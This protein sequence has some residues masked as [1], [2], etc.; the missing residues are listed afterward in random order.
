MYSVL[1]CH[2]QIH[3]HFVHRHFEYDLTLAKTVTVG[4]A[5]HSNLLEKQRMKKSIGY[6]AS[7]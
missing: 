5:H 7:D 6:E 2:E 4:D 3:R 1:E